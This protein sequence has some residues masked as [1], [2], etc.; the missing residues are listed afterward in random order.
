MIHISTYNQ[1]P[2][3]AA[4]RTAFSDVPDFVDASRSRHCVE[5]G[6]R[7]PFNGPALSLM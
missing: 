1:P 3:E 6:V 7:P 4:R 5:T 2:A